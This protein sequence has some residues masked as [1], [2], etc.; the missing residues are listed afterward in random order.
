[1]G[2]YQ[3]DEPQIEAEYTERQ[4]AYEDEHADDWKYTD[5]RLNYAN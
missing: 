5:E 3:G 1:M 4:Q 2:E